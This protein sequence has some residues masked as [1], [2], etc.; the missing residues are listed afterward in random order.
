MKKEPVNFKESSK[1]IFLEKEKGK[2][3]I[4]IELQ[5]QK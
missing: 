2:G 3:S 1:R 5:S 4:T